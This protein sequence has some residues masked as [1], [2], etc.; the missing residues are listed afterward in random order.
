MVRP[1][2]LGVG[3]S[4]HRHAAVLR[5]RLRERDPARQR[6]VG[7]REP[8]VGRVLVEREHRPAGRLDGHA[9]VPEEEVVALQQAAH[10]LDDRRH[11]CE[12]VDRVEDQVRLVI[13]VVVGLERAAAGSACVGEQA[14][15]ERSGRTGGEHVDRPEG[16]V[17]EEAGAQRHGWPTARINFVSKYLGTMTGAVPWLRLEVWDNDRLARDQF[18]GE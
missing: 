11:A 5:S 12:L 3:A 7:R 14:A 10:R 6:A 8:P 4:H 2:A 17:A 13:Q 18:V 1:L 15:A 9:G 16:A